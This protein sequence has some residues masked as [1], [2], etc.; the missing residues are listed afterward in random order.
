MSKQDEILATF[1]SYE[2]LNNK[3]YSAKSALI[4]L[5]RPALNVMG[6]RAADYEIIDITTTVLSTDRPAFA[7]EY[8][9]GRDYGK[10]TIYIDACVA[11][12]DDPAA[13]H[14]E[15]MEAKRKREN[16]ELLA[17]N[18]ALRLKRYRDAGLSPEE[19]NT[20]EAARNKLEAV[21]ASL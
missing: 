3:A 21:G 5:L 18:E 7:V 9:A 2:D 4:A 14:A 13:A 17:R 6:F 10:E 12:A 11:Y 20:I 15:F 16:A 8:D 1:K 19:I